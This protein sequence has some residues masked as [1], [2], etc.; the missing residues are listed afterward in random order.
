MSEASAEPGSPFAARTVLIL[1][2][3]GVVSFCALAVLSAY[4]PDLRQGRNG[5]AHVLSRSAVGYAGVAELLRRLRV[6]VI[7]S[8][9]PPPSRR[10]SGLAVL[11]PPPGITSKELERYDFAGPVLIVLPKWNTVQ[12]RTNQDWVRAEGLLDAKLL[13]ANLLK[14]LAPGSSVARIPGAVWPRLT[15]VPGSSSPGWTRQIGAVSNLQHL[16]GP[17]W[18]ALVTDQAGHVL[19]AQQEHGKFYV[20]AEPDL[21]NTHGMRDA[22]RAQAAVAMLRM[23]R[24][25]DGPILF[26]ATLHGL[27]RSHSPFKLAFEP[28]FL[29]AT[30]CGLAAALLLGVR[31]L[32]RFGP[33]ARPGRALALGKTALAENTAGIVRMA[34]REGAMAQPY[35]AMTKN[36]VAR[37]VGV[38]REM[39]DER[40]LRLLDLLAGSR[41]SQL[42]ASDLM[43]EAERVR[44]RAGLVGVAQKLHRWRVE[45]TGEG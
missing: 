16:I 33:A 23:L 3:V 17:G 38:P 10:T 14:T 11:T 25:G 5:G 9:G 1:L 24:A 44:D 41:G 4:A 2:V 27:T 21:L 30:L 6:T 40:G 7:A 28:P 8:R 37:A 15:A 36:A 32:N 45:M 29:A 39:D 42:R 20:L 12:L 26:D 13:S 35:A 22:H 34:Q 43:A 18:R 31:A 19:L